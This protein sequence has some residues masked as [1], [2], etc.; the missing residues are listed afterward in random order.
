MAVYITVN[1]ANIA[2]RFAYTLTH[3]KTSPLIRSGLGDCLNDNP[4][5]PPEKLK[6]PNMLPGA[7]YGADFQ[8]D[9]QFPGSKVCPQPQVNF[10]R[11][12]YLLI[13]IASP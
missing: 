2:Y 9:M 3:D 8:C 13:L 4:R 6:Y 5:S 11:G 10:S 1:V 7:M 12:F